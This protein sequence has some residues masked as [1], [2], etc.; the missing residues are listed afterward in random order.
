MHEVDTPHAIWALA[1]DGETVLLRR[2]G[3]EDRDRALAMHRAMSPESLY[4][5]FFGV[6]ERAVRE[7]AERVSTPGRPRSGALFRQAGVTATR[8][9]GDLIAV[10]ALLHAQ[11]LPD[12]ASVAVIGNA[13]GAGVPAA[14]ACVDAGPAV[15]RFGPDLEADLR[16]LLPAGAAC[17]NP[18]DTTTATVDGDTLRACVDRVLDAGHVDA[19]VLALAPTALGDP[20]GDIL[21]GPAVRERPVVVIAPERA[22]SVELLPAVGGAVPVY[23][24]ARTAAVALAHAYERSMWLTRPRGTVPPLTDVDRGAARSLADRFLAREPDGGWLPPRECARLLGAYGIEV[25]PWRQ[26]FD[27]E[28]AVALA[29][30]LAPLGV[31][32]AVVLKA[33]G[34]HIVHKSDVGGVRLRLVGDDAV[35]A[36]FT[37]LAHRIGALMESVVVQ[38]MAASGVELIAGVTQDEVLGPLVLFGLGGVATDVLAD[39]GARLTPLTDLDAHALPAESRGAPLLYGHPGPG[40]RPAARLAVLAGAAVIAAGAAAYG[41]RGAIGRNT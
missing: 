10:A 30:E 36:A 31:D 23:N 12:G 41:V 19:V 15:P 1:A 34:P 2:P 5:R 3:P 16:A 21:A 18:V 6:S 28:E 9:L 35:R 39:H 8:T 29:R 40:L 32:G 27:A 25:S 20:L 37:D 24:D 11:P 14:D 7:T 17:A 13:G 4:L 22:A 33:Y 38:P 26:A